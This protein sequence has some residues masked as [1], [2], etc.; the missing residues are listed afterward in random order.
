MDVQP[1]A[2]RRTLATLAAAVIACAGITVATA[3]PAS[4]GQPGHCEEL[5]IENPDIEKSVENIAPCGVVYNGGTVPI[6]IFNNWDHE[7]PGHPETGDYDSHKTALIWDYW[8]TNRDDKDGST[9]KLLPIRTNSQSLGPDFHDTDGFYIGTGMRALVDIITPTNGLLS[10]SCVI[11]PIYYKI[12][13]YSV[14]RVNVLSGPS[15][16]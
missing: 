14:F 13:L 11:G 6:G 16:C 9:A 12:P 10:T 1:S 4:A 2:R 15:V 5:D 3:A 7:V 8:S